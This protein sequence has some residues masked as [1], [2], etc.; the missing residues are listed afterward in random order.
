MPSFSLSWLFS[1][2]LPYFLF[3]FILFFLSFFFCLFKATP[4]AYGSSQAR[5]QITQP[6]PQPQQ[7]GIQPA[8]ETYAMAHGNARSLTCWTSPGIEPVSSWILAGFVNHWAMMETPSVFLLFLLCWNKLPC[9]ELPDERPYVASSSQGT[10]VLSQ[11]TH[12]IVNP[13]NNHMRELEGW[14]FPSWVWRC[15]QP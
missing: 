14:P 15:L 12:D 6:V 3:Y 7:R 2:F 9:C 4:A 5:G 13:A 11:I 1:V 10:E 8:S